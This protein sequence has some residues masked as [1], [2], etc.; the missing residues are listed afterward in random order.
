MSFTWSS[1]CEKIAG[2]LPAVLASAPLNSF[3]A[4]R[5]AWT[6]G[7]VLDGGS[8]HR[9]ADEGPLRVVPERLRDEGA[10]AEVH[11]DHREP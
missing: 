4:A 8:D 1:T 9:G 3:S 7:S 5:N 10:R 11:R 2:A 6:F